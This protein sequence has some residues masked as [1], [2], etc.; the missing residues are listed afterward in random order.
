MRSL[1]RQL[2]AAILGAV[3]LAVGVSL[4]VGIL[5]TRDATRDAVQD[6]LARE[7]DQLAS[8]VG[9]LP[10]AAQG[11]FLFQLP[12]PPPD[13]AAPGEE[14]PG[15]PPLP[16]GV[17][18]GPERLPPGAVPP[19]ISLDDAADLLPESA[20][21]D[22]RGG[23]PASGTVTIDGE[24]QIFEARAV[25]DTVVLATRPDLEDGDDFR[26]FLSALLIASGLAI[27]LAGGVAALL[28]RRLA[29]P[30]GRVAEAS[31]VLAA[32]KSPEPLPRERTEE[33]SAL[34]DAFNAMAAQL[35]RAREAERSVLLSVSH[36]LRT[37]LTAVQGYAEGIEDGTLEPAA[38][39]R[40]DR[41]G[42][43]AARAP[44]RR[45]ARARPPAP[46]APRVPLRAGRPRRGPRRGGGAVAT[47]GRCRRGRAGNRGGRRRQSSP[48]TTGRVLQVATNLIE[49]AIRVTPEGGR[50]TA[51]AADE[52]VHDRRLRPGDPARRHRERFR[53]LPPARPARSRLGGRRRRRARDRAR[54]DRGDG[55]LG[56]RRESSRRGRAVYG[57][58]AAMIAYE[59]TGE[60]PPIVVL[61]GFAGTRADWD[62]AFLAAL[63]E[64]N[65]LIL[66][67]N[68]GMGE[69]ADGGDPFTVEDLAADTI[70]LVEAL[71]LE[72]P[73]VLG[74]SMGGMI[75]MALALERPD[76]AGSLVLL[77]TESGAGQT[78]IT[79]DVGAKLRDL[80][81]SPAEQAK[82]LI[83]V[84]FTPERAPEI[85][86]VALDVIAAARAQLDPVVVERQW[87]A[88][89]AWDRAGATGRL[90]EIACPTLV[91]TG[92]ED[93]VFSPANSAALA[94]AIGGSWLARFPR[95]SH[96]FMADHPV[97]LTGLVGS[98][99]AAQK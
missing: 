93:V 28:S 72:R 75:A 87:Q 22:L 11:D 91:A 5:L 55:R 49:N 29:E 31:R 68:R 18:F 33:L 63:A 99:L 85:E 2:F 14:G 54:A 12:A 64:G 36:D 96:A 39:A 73:C 42:I 84:L 80:T 27:L 9:A 8:R 34:A 61:N 56:R 32:G 66:V 25:G 24:N 82:G 10:G 62:P 1:R 44:R 58:A 40:G 88:M 79:D 94:A 77:A 95:A 71:G 43:E 70:A 57:K 19:A 6:N 41:A 23:E 21:E 46:G 74:W 37:P 83:S 92:T 17:P 81:S 45:P 20:V 4:A 7:A 69:S 78:P 47:A 3:L 30:L 76:L 90:G 53:A 60:G 86:A 65:E 67:D 35:E 48:P 89:E 59:R 15:P 13:D 26:N 98:F 52:L 51:S 50:V 16:G 97:A 38:A